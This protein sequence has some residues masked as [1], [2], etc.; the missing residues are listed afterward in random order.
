MTSIQPQL[1]VDRPGEALR[2][3]AAAFG[4]TVLHCVARGTTSSR[5]SRSV[6]RRSG[7]HQRHRP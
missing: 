7:L 3:Y 6:A 1:W 5:N 2:F 4:A